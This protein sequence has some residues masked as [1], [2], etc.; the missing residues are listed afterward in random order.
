MTHPIYRDENIMGMAELM[1]NFPDWGA[2]K[3]ASEYFDRLPEHIIEEN[4]LTFEETVNDFKRAEVFLSIKN[5]G[6]NLIDSGKYDWSSE[7]S[8]RTLS[9]LKLSDL[10]KPFQ[11]G[12]VLYE[13]YKIHFNFMTENYV[14][15][16]Y[17]HPSYNHR[18]KK[19]ELQIG[20]EGCEIL[21][22]EDVGTIGGDLDILEDKNERKLLYAFFSM[23]LYL[24]VFKNDSNRVSSPRTI[25]SKKSKKIQKHKINIVY[26]SQ[27]NT[28]YEGSESN[29]TGQKKSDKTWIVR[30]H[31]RNQYYK[32]TDENRPKWID[33]Y[34]KGDG[35]EE[36]EK[37]YKL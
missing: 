14:A 28:I 21:H 11:A 33:P 6:H 35:K 8:E 10:K 18:D 4:D 31:W 1:S 7:V 27:K 26:L 23:L 5:N 22:T 13:D 3:C 16:H 30:G 25:V 12:T 15:I 29:P 20:Y 24:S 19:G 37:L 2:F 32:G 36:V 17:S 9:A 34:W